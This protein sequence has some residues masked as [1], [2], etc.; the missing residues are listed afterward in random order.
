MNINA[1]T[2]LYCILGNPVGHSLSPIIHNTAFKLTGINA[3][4]LAFTPRSL[5]EGIDAL[6]ALG[7]RGASITIPYKVDAIKLLDS[8]DPASALIGSINTVHNHEGMLTGYNTDGY[9]ALKPFTERNFD[10]GGKRIFVIGNGGSARAV[11]YTFLEHGARV[12]IAGRNTVNISGLT[13]ELMMRYPGRVDSMLL[14]GID[15]SFMESLDAIVNTTP[16][17]MSPD[18][19]HSPIDTALI[20]KRHL[21]FDIVY[22][23]HDTFLLREAKKKGCEIIHGM[24]MLLYQGARQFEIWT[25]HTAPVL[26][27]SKAL[28]RVLRKR[29]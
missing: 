8:V 16:V 6:R 22:S 14:K 20:D 23:P 11:A 18:T 2:E 10:M 13:G 24:E 21:V 4:Y 15:P 29:A 27:I 26:E 9:G 7:I 12:I 1:H 28:K 17:G 25:G 19:E 3:V 5:K